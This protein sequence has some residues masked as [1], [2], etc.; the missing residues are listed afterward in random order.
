MNTDELLDRVRDPKVCTDLLHR[1]LAAALE[2][3]LGRSIPDP[4]G[5]CSCTWH[6]Q[7]A[8]GGHTEHLLEYD[9]ACPEH[10]KHVYNPRTGIWE[11]AAREPSDAQV[12]VA[13]RTWLGLKPDEAAMGNWIH[14]ARLNARRALRAAFKAGGEGR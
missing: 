4:N 10:S 11:L 12:E 9:P 8:G 6:S 2:S 13:W 3:A 1:D 7:D 14:E 5:G